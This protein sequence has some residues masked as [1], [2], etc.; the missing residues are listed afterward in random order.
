VALRG[1]SGGR[2][3]VGRQLDAVTGVRVERDEISDVTELL[4]RFAIKRQMG[5]KTAIN[6]I[7]FV[8][9]ANFI[10]SPRIFCTAMYFFTMRCYKRLS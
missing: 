9:V 5:E 2:F 3:Q 6:A 8:V 1:I 7:C 4:P 10:L